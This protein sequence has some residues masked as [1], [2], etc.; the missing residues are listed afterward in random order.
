[1]ATSIAEWLAVFFVIWAL[2]FILKIP[3]E[4][5]ALIPIFLIASSAG[6]VSMIPGGVGSFDLVFVGNTKYRNC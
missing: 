3:I 6:I 1:M 2:T 4:L 5:S